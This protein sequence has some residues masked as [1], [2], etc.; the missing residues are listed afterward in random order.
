VAAAV[1]VVVAAVVVVVVALARTAGINTACVWHCQAALACHPLLRLRAS[2]GHNVGALRGT[3]A[4]TT[5][6]KALAH[7]FL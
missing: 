1:V 2:E 4:S 7:D 5:A 3:P 6:P